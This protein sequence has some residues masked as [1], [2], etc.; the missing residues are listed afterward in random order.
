MDPLLSKERRCRYKKVNGRLPREI[1]ST[2]IG[3]SSSMFESGRTRN[4]SQRVT[5]IGWIVCLLPPSVVVSSSD[6]LSFQ[7]SSQ[8]F[9]WLGIVDYGCRRHCR[10]HSEKQHPC[11]LFDGSRSRRERMERFQE[12]FSQSGHVSLRLH[13]LR[14]NIDRVENLRVW[15][16]FG[17]IPGIL[18][19]DANP[20]RYDHRFRTSRFR[21]M[22]A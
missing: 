8:P 21:Q 7:A 18:D 19:E 9:E 4:E 1:R 15:S 22:H 12:I 6:V 13:H 14:Q 11:G 20:G 16:P 2:V 17:G 3:M 10:S 5:A